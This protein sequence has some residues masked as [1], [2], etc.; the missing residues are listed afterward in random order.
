MS[1]PTFFCNINVLNYLIGLEIESGHALVPLSMDPIDL[2]LWFDFYEEEA[3]LQFKM[4]RRGEIYSHDTETALDIGA[5]TVDKKTKTCTGSTQ[6]PF[7]SQNATVLFG[8]CLKL[9]AYLEERHLMDQYGDLDPEEAGVLIELNDD[10]LTFTVVEGKDRPDLV[11]ATL[12]GGVVTMR[13]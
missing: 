6:D 13:P 5:L 12:F 9:S 3:S 1:K 4:Y 8:A 10:E 2:P 11:C 7:L